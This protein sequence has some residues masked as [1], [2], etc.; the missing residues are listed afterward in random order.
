MI[1][2]IA[3]REIGLSPSEVDEFLSLQ[4]RGDYARQIEMLRCK[5]YCV[6]DCVHENEHCI[7]K[8]DYII[9]EI[10][11]KIGDNREVVK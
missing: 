6:L 2:A 9:C 3:L 10:S 8:I 4:E 7:H 1:S 11:E 5:R